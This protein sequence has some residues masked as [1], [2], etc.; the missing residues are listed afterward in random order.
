[1]AESLERTLA[2]ELRRVAAERGMHLTHLADESGLA[3]SYLWRV[4]GCKSS[5]TLDTVQRLAKVLRVDPRQLFGIVE[6]P[7]YRHTEGRPLVAADS[8]R[9]TRD[10]PKRAPRRR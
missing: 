8:T 2:R 3:R 1:M 4:L 5:A 6:P 9:P 10:K 7:R